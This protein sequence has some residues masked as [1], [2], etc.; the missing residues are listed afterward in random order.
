MVLYRHYPWEVTNIENNRNRH[1]MSLIFLLVYIF[2]VLWFTVLKRSTGYH[3]AQFE[4]FWS[5][6]RWFAGDTDLGN[7][8]MANI[9]MFIPFGFLVSSVLPTLNRKVRAGLVA[10]TAILFSLTIETLQ[11]FLMRGLFEWDDVFS[12]TLGAVIELFTLVSMLASG[13]RR[14]AVITSISLVFMIV[15]LGVYIHG[16]GA[17]GV[18]AD[19]TS[20]AYCF[21]IDKALVHDGKVELNGF[22]FRYDHPMG[23]PKLLLHS[24]DNGEQIML[25][26]EYGLVR[27][28]VNEYF[29]CD[30]DYTNVGFTA[31]GEAE[32]GEY[33]VLIQWPLTLPLSTG[34]FISSAGVRYFPEESFTAPKIDAE[35]IAAGIPRVYRPDY[36]CW[37]YQYHNDLYWIADQDFY[38]EEDNT[39]YIQYQMWTTQIQNLPEKRLAHHHYWDNIGGYFEDYELEGNFGDYRV[40]KREIPTAYSVTS[41]VTGYYKNGEWIWKNYFRPIY[42][43]RGAGR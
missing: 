30:R 10:G 1:M 11:L 17:S 31:S 16:R 35:F 4:L 36:H 26:M 38:F 24:T 33:E 3:V 28:D 22:A 32:D 34:V 2:S 7:E 19:T 8:I 42:E 25:T 41:I 23:A 20:R 18:E 9:A 29:L 5:Y 15:C 14:M 27:P 43:F 37:V 40:M 39:T 21:Q 6:K 12:N 13:K